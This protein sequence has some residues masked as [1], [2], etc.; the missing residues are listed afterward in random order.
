[1]MNPAYELKN[2]AIVVTCLTEG[3]YDDTLASR[4]IRAVDFVRALSADNILDTQRTEAC[5]PDDTYCL[6]D[7][8]RDYRDVTIGEI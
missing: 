6:D 8:E 1:M 7:F 4:A 5:D 2:V 3:V